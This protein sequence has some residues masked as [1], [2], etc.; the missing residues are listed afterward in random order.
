M[1][2]WALQPVLFRRGGRQVVPRQHA[3]LGRFLPYRRA[4]GET[5]AP[6][7]L[8]S[9]LA[10]RGW[11]V[12]LGARGL[13]DMLL[14]LATVA[15][16]VDA[17]RQVGRPIELLYVGPRTALMRRCGLPLTV[18][19]A[20][21]GSRICIG[22]QQPVCV[23]PVPERP[24]TW[25]DATGDDG[26]EVHAALPMRYYLEIEQALGVALPLDSAPVPAFHS[27]VRSPSPFY[28]VFVETTSWP[29]RKSYGVEGFA[30][31]AT[32]LVHARSAPWRFSIVPEPST[33]ASEV[34]NAFG[35]VQCEVLAGLS[36]ADCVDVFAAAELVIGNDTGLTHLAAM[37]IRNDRSGPQVVGIYGRHGYA[38]WTTGLARHHAV[39]TR[40][41]QMM[42]V[43]DACPVRDGIDDAAWGPS[44]DVRCLPAADIASFA[45]GCAGWW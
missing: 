2:P 34:E 14:G 10:A 21:V 23:D 33:S 11:R 22:G 16:L 12:D 36:A 29:V 19:H 32:E 41:S 40:F 30:T 9:A 8:F 1:N 44:S 35:D 24:P 13:G 3:P 4:I 43:T 27:T 31:I 38:K 42:S 6:T 26:V 37:T 7:P 45:G 20:S 17:R 15:A 28:V 39:A 25:L 18:E 5:P